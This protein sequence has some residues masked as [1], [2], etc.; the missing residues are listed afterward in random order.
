MWTD[1]AIYGYCRL[2]L[3]SGRQPV[4][5]NVSPD[6]NIHNVSPSTLLHFK[7]R[8]VYSVCGYGRERARCVAYSSHETFSISVGLFLETSLVN[9]KKK[10]ACLS[11]WFLHFR[12]YLYCNDLDIPNSNFLL[13]AVRQNKTRI[14]YRTELHSHKIYACTDLEG[15]WGSWRFRLPGFSENRQM[16]VVKLLALRTGRLNPPPPPWRSLVLIS[17][18]GWMEPR[19]VV[20][21]EELN[22]RKI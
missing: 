12:L 5:R 2:C 13:R 7:P 15:S 17:V 4:G 20:L 1:N 11:S 19:A 18:R 22:C 14:T 9:L 6:D 21:P 3:H 16:K 8:S 10:F